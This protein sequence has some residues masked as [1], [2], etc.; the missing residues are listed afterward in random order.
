MAAPH[1]DE[2]RVVQ[3]RLRADQGPF[4]PKPGL[5]IIDELVATV[6]SQHISDVNSEGAF[7]QLKERFPT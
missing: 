2:I 7:A 5:P 1:T 6:L 4:V 3:R